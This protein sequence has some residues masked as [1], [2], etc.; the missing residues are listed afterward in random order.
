M[1]LN[2]LKKIKEY[3]DIYKFDENIILKNPK[4]EFRYLCYY[5]LDI[6]REYSLPK[7]QLNQSNEAVL[8]EYR[9][10]PHLEFLI[11]NMIFKLGENWSHTIVCGRLNY[12]YIKNICS[13]ISENIRI[14]ETE[15]DNLNQSTYSQLLVNTDFWE[16]FYGEKIL[17]YQ[18]D[19]CIFKENID[20]FLKW[21][22][23]GAPW[24][25]E[26][27][28]N[29]HGV[30]N[31]GF[32]L[33]TKK[34]MLE[35]ISN[36]NIYDT[37]YQS[38]TLSFIKNCYL[39]TPP[40][41]VYFSLNMIRLK[42]G[43][44]ADRNEA[45]KFSS[46]CIFNED[47]LGGHNFWIKNPYWR[48]QVFLNVFKTC[49]ITSPYG[50]N[51]GGGEYYLLY[52]AKYF[53]I[54]KKCI[55]LLCVDEKEE[56]KIHTIR[57]ILGEE[58]LKYFLFYPFEKHNQ[59]YRKVDY[60]FDMSNSKIPNFEGFSKDFSHNYFHCQFPF[61]MKENITILDKIRINTY[62]RIIL[63]S[64]FTK[65]YYEK[66]IENIL[67]PQQSVH[68]IYPPCY[69]NSI[70]EIDIKKE[71]LSFVL[72][73]RIFRYNPLANNK[74]FDIALESF[75]KISMKGYNNFSVSIICKV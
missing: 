64:P 47:S 34:C 19:S 31:G 16:Q 8:I 3:C 50:L 44:V 73:G 54:H 12:S 66:C 20:D 17:I 57:T 45:Y 56:V 4:N 30:G 10:L 49:I 75:E 53:I 26:Q 59:F 48:E 6:I 21:D 41:D 69:L 22:Y 37:S 14:I 62:H 43:E 74:N 38:S 18:E 2:Y 70:E 68:I 23:I 67:T 58:Y 13:N 27:N 9:P 63:N 5:F 65:K 52:I 33:R 60:H 15:Y 7:I 61:D 1:F 46:E 24:P 36:I 35:V 51:I 11:R 39:S 29:S 28:D 40:E 72:V 25:E 71:E 55:I 32:S 42:I